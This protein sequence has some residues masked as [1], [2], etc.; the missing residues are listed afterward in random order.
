MV[1][2]CSAFRNQHRYAIDNWIAAPAVRAEEPVTL[3]T[4]WSQAGRAGGWST[5]MSRRRGNGWDR[6]AWIATVLLHRTS[7]PENLRG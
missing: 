3:Q 5:A 6:E 7:F 1:G 4:K 2:V